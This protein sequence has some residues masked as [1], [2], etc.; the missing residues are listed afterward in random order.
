MA[1]DQRAS[2]RVLVD[3]RDYGAAFALTPTR[4]LTAAHVLR[5]RNSELI[6]ES[7]SY[8]PNSGAAIEVDGVEWDPQ[9]D[10]AVLYLRTPAPAVIAAARGA[11]SGDRWEGATPATP[12]DPILHGTIRERFARRNDGGHDT[13]AIQLAVDEELGSYRGYSGSAVHLAAAPSPIV[14]LLVEQAPTRTVGA[15]GMSANVLF[16]T[17]IEPILARFGLERQVTRTVPA[18][19][20]GEIVA[21][22]DRL[23]EPESARTLA[24]PGARPMLADVATGRFMDRRYAREVR[25]RVAASPTWASGD[26]VPTDATDVIWVCGASGVGKSVILLQAARELAAAGEI[27]HL[28]GNLPTML[29]TAVEFW[30]HRR[31]RVVLVLDDGWAN[32]TTDQ[33]AWTA[34]LPVLYQWQGP[35]PVVVTAGPPEQLDRF[36]AFAAQYGRIRVDV[37]PVERL[38]DTERAQYLHWYERRTGRPAPDPPDEVL[39]TLLAFRLELLHDAAVTL[40][41]FALRFLVRA[42]TLGIDEELLAALAANRHDLPV[43]G[44][45]FNGKT[46]ELETLFGQSILGYSGSD[47]GRLVHPTIAEALYAEMVR[48]DDVRGAARHAIA[49]LRAETHPAV[50]AALVRG[51]TSE[52]VQSASAPT[53]VAAFLEDLWAWL[54]SLPAAQVPPAIMFAWLRVP[55]PEGWAPS[56]DRVYRVARAWM[57][58]SDPAG[59]DWANF[60]GLAWPFAPDSD[61]GELAEAMTAWLE[62]HGEGPQWTHSWSALWAYQPGTRLEHLARNWL[63]N[64]SAVPGW[65]YLFEPL[66]ESG[67]REEWLLAGALRMLDDL[68][69]TRG[70]VRHWRRIRALMST[71]Q[72]EADF[73]LSRLYRSNLLTVSE[74]AARELGRLIRRGAADADL[75]ADRL[76]EPGRLLGLTLLGRELGTHP[77]SR[78]AT[79]DWLKD[80]PLDHSEWATRFGLAHAVRTERQGPELFERALA[81][82]RT[83][84]ESPDWSQVWRRLHDDEVQNEDLAELGRTWLERNGDRPDW[85][86][87]YRRLV[88]ATPADERLVRLGVAWA[89]EHEGRFDCE[90]VLESLAPLRGDPLV[91]R[92]VD[93]WL[94]EYG[95]SPAWNFVWRAAIRATEDPTEHATLVQLATGWLTDR[96]NEP[97]WTFVWADLAREGVS[98][99]DHLERGF[100]WL[101]GRQH[102]AEWNH[103][104]QFLFEHHPDRRAELT[105][106]GQAFLDGGTDRQGWDYVWQAL[107]GDLAH[108]TDF[109]E[110]GLRR[111]DHKHSDAAWNHVWE[112]MLDVADS[113]RPQLYDIG[114]RWLAT[115]L[116]HPGWPYV[117]NRMLSMTSGDPEPLCE[118]ARQWLPGRHEA[119]G[120]TRVWN[121]VAERGGTDPDLAA[122]AREWLPEHQTHPGWP[123]MFSRLFQHSPADRPPLRDSGIQWL[124]THRT[125]RGWSRVWQ[126]LAAD[127]PGRETL[128]TLGRHWLHGHESDP[129]WAYVWQMLT[130]HC[131]SDPEFIDASCE[132]LASQERNT[133]WSRVWLSLFEI[134]PSRR[135]ELRSSALRWL[136]SQHAGGAWSYVWKRLV[137]DGADTDRVLD[138]GANWLN[139]HESNPGWPHVWA[140]LLERRPFDRRIVDSGTRWLDS[141]P[142]N[143][144][145]Q[146][147]VRNRLARL[148]RERAQHR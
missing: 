102:T 28:L 57:N 75:S 141:K 96:E 118:L 147:Y 3:G 61:R 89:Y 107:S 41:D 136:D 9:L 6:R 31:E 148:N 59:G 72:Q 108:D 110:A 87:V 43:P 137:D 79:V 146:H 38:N 125:S 5:D 94:Q 20:G 8:L 80:V 98:S 140:P 144:K 131:S 37:V 133:G 40:T 93:T 7:L 32:E 129:G 78:R 71:S 119:A 47:A 12:Q 1:P 10:A 114:H 46:A 63:A 52:Q 115:N 42:R 17:P 112:K 70:E 85:T 117:F 66:Y 26:A 120:W 127:R 19:P 15:P 109:L 128:T 121:S 86:Q 22:D 139:G 143:T 35:R 126:L 2:G 58:A 33:G 14:G 49:C 97:G 64:A 23:G 50:H 60:W 90:I 122:L 134:A 88:A 30:Q 132:W 111:L 142:Q 74:R 81:W 48:R 39:F 76:D 105:E 55:A 4:A 84:R 68:P 123:F 25:N 77:A 130:P 73:L 91:A 62:S 16:A 45:L 106:L 56:P 67:I 27:V 65:G 18:P 145:A 83:H 21:A 138:V 11:T 69:V 29:G 101:D 116:E 100:R 44:N 51:F 36:R 124:E 113:Y 135:P 82:L 54:A 92:L 34:A 95:D 53:F 104:W 99:S 13:V 24:P 103:V